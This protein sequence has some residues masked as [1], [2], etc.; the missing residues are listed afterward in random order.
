MRTQENVIFLDLWSNKIFFFK[1]NCPTKNA[2]DTNHRNLHQ[3]SSIWQLPNRIPTHIQIFEGIQHLF[4]CINNNTFSNQYRIMFSF[5]FQFKP[6]PLFFF[7]F[8]PTERSSC[9]LL[10]AAKSTPKAPSNRRAAVDAYRHSHVASLTNCDAH[11]PWNY[12]I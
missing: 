12:T 7:G 9:M 4:S 10:G 8:S 3:F 5:K 1:Y 2:P 11:A 6:Y